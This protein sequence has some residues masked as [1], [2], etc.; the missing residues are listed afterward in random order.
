MSDSGK[1]CGT[2]PRAL[3]VTTVPVTLWSFLLP[4]AKALRAEGWR[5]DALSGFSGG[6]RPDLKGPPDWEQAFDELHSVKWSRSVRS[7]L[8]YRRLAREI[9]SLVIDGGYRVVHTH[10]PIASLITRLALRKVGGV[11]VI[12]TAHGFHFYRGQH[13]RLQGWLFRRAEQYCARFTDLLVVMNDEDEGAAHELVAFAPRCEVVRIDG[14]GIDLDDYVPP[15]LGAEREAELRDEYQLPE[16][17]YV[18][19]MIAEL[20]DNKRHRLALYAARLLKQSHPRLRWLFIGSG[21]V[22]QAL[23]IRV[24]AERLPVTFA[25]Q[26]DATRLRELFA[27]IDLGIL[28]SERE[29]LPRSLMEFSAAGIPIAGTRTRGIIDEVRD[30]RA[31][32]AGSAGDGGVGGGALAEVVG[33]IADDAGLAVELAASQKAYAREHFALDVILPKY[34]ALYI[35]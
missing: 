15:V 19:G 32:A 16:D 22:E 7:F 2:P 12:Y 10:T 21:P 4:L 13:R 25:G 11:R 18:V 33:R 24:N 28:V 30:E 35:V 9:R 34:L 23:R 17:S 8:R 3:F 29:G 6:V 26:V 27:L 14:V 20:N 31:L 5:V 1:D